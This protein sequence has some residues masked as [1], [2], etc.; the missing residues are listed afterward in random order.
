M[1]WQL[2]RFKNIQ[3][4]HDNEKYRLN[5]GDIYNKELENDILSL[6]KDYK[7][8]GNKIH[9]SDLDD[10]G[11][12]QHSI[13]GKLMDDNIISDNGVILKKL[14]SYENLFQEFLTKEQTKKVYDILIEGSEEI[15][16]KTKMIPCSDFKELLNFISDYLKY[17]NTIDVDN[18]NELKEK[19]QILYLFTS[20]Y[21]Q[22][23]DDLFLE[24]SP[25]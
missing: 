3:D 5:S 2:V 21:D 24:V 6:K 12:K 9:L 13:W 23:R 22:K 14:S 25:D 16:Q 8:F 11:N 17:S 19:S 15:E 20:L 1:F 7:I 10:F 18:I 4:F